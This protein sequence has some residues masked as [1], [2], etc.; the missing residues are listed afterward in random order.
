MLLEF[1]GSKRVG[2]YQRAHSHQQMRRNVGVMLLSGVGLERF[3]VR[4][5]HILACRVFW[6]VPDLH[7]EDSIDVSDV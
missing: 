3:A 5:F 6:H 1:R 2:L 4:S 7:L